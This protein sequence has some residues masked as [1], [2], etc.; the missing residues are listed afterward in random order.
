MNQIEITGEVSIDQMKAGKMIAHLLVD[1]I[2]YCVKKDLAPAEAQLGRA[3]VEALSAFVFQEH[4]GRDWDEATLVT[5]F[6]GVPIT[7]PELDLSSL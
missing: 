5:E 3:D 6:C 1:M 4:Y 2:D 7:S